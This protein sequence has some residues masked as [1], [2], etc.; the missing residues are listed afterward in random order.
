MGRTL[1][2]VLLPAA[3]V[4]VS[5]VRLEDPRL[6]GEVAVVAG[7]AIAPALVRPG[8]TRLAAAGLAALTAFWVAFGSEPWEL[9]PFRD[10]RVLGPVADNVR[11]GVGDYYGVVLPFD[12]ARR[13]EMHALLLAAVFGFVLALGLLVAARRPLS[14]AAVTVAGAG[15][16]A[17]LLGEGAVGIG[18]LALAAA[19]SIPLVLR[20]RSAP[21]LAVGAVAASVVVAG[22][23]WASSATSFTRDAVLEW[24]SW[25]FRGAP[26][27]ALGVRFVWD[28]QYDG[29]SFPPTETTVLRIRGPDRAQ[30]WRAATLDTFIADR[31][32]EQPAFVLRRDPDGPLARDQLTPDGARDER[33]WLEQRVEVKALV[34]ER[35]VA[36]GTPM[37]V[38]APSLGSVFSSP[39]GA[40]RAAGTL[41]PG[42]RYRLWSYVPDPVPTALASAS[43]RFPVRIAPFLTVW[44]RELPAFGAPRRD[45][46]VR[47]LL[48]DPSY[49]DFGAYRPVYEQARRVS[50]RADSP[51][52]AVLALESWFRR[53]GGFRYEEQP[54]LSADR[55]LVH[56]V[57]SGRAGYCQHFAGAMA[58][59]ARLL[60]VPARVAVGFTS[61]RYEDGAWTVTDHNAHAWVEVWFPGHGWVPFDPT[62]GRGTFSSLYSFATNNA[63]TL[64]ALRRG[65]LDSLVNTDGRGLTDGEIAAEALPK[66]TERPS[67]VAL[68]LVLALAGAAVIGTMKWCVHRL[69]YLTRD[70]RGTSA[71]SRK[72]LEAFLRDQGVAVPASATLDDLRH[73]LWNELGLDARPFVEAAGR[74]RFGAPSDAPR[75]AQRARRELRA[76]LR[77]VRAQLSIWARVRGFV[78]LRSFRGWQG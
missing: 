43:R 8:V 23:A 25:D 53:R 72:E 5:W 21:T 16:P 56:F 30:Y 63:A 27:R 77:R 50:A 65:A 39:G 70:P 35:L 17:T 40:V 6:T 64:D 19:L 71:A 78:S 52:A 48:E 13:S 1:A 67:I 2:A 11:R 45:A 4:G 75:E 29:I 74:G 15:W 14:A 76:L 9:V 68:V 49:T 73:A 69:R 7:L 32:F 33:S 55:P 47:A 42:T 60:G 54:S 57:G 3:A 46:A 12:P 31:W 26:A 24:Q 62:P 34:D 28:A 18:A 10:Q 44:G 59:M 51:Y 37:A 58:L 22:A 38:D 36:A 20:S 41:R 61:G 66:R